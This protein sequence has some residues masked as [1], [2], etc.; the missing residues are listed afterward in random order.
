MNS[1]KLRDNLHRMH[2]GKKYKG[3]EYFKMQKENLRKRPTLKYSVKKS[4]PAS[5]KFGMMASYI[6]LLIAKKLT[7]I[8]SERILVYLL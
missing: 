3:V 4:A 7:D 6:S 8:R 2:A 1:S 5:M